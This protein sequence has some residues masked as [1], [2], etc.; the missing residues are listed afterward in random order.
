MT[1]RQ[2]R[3]S[4]TPAPQHGLLQATDEPAL[5][6]AAPP[7]QHGLADQTSAGV[8]SQRN[9]DFVMPDL[10]DNTNTVA[11]QAQWPSHHNSQQAADQLL[12]S[13]HEGSRGTLP[14]TTIWG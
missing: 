10:L 12:H 1:L 14:P 3:R 11:C 6:T 7:R 8:P 13:V 2:W 4:A 5:A 9:W